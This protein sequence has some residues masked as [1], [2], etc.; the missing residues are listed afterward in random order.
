MRHHRLSCP[1][2]IFKAANR[3]IFNKLQYVLG[4]V[5][6][7]SFYFG[8]AKLVRFLTKTEHVQKNDSKSVFIR[9]LSYFVNKHNVESTNI[10]T[11]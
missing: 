3:I 8:G 9:K 10:G 5:G 11:F 4:S 1:H 6:L 7:L 2:H